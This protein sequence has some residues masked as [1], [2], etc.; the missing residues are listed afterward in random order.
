M[1]D[2]KEGHRRSECDVGSIE[3]YEVAAGR[4]YRVRY[5][6]PD[7]TQ[8]DK[9]GFRTKRDAQL[10]LASVEI[11]KSRGAY[12]DPSKTRATVS[13][14]MRTWMKARPDM[15][16]TTRTRVDGII[17]NYIDPPLG[18]IPI[19]ELNRLRVQEWTANL[20]GSPASIRKVVNVLSGAL[21]LAVDDGRLP[22]NPAVKL[23]LPKQ[24]RTS[25]LYL[26]HD[27]VAALAGAVSARPS[28]SALGYDTLILTMSYCGLRWGE[29]S[30]L[31]TRDVDLAK[32]RLTVQQTVV[33]DKGY[34]RVEAPK[35][36]EHRSIP[37]PGFLIEP[38][39]RQLAG[40]NDDTPVFYG[41]LTKTWLRNHA[42]RKGWLDPAA[43]EIGVPGLTPHELR[44]T[45][46]SLA[47]S[48]GANVKAVQRILGHASAAITL[49]VY[50]DLFDDDLDTVA[51]ALDN[52]AMQ[53]D[54]GKMW[55]E[56]QN[57]V[58]EA[59]K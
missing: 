57:R 48:A 9:R 55:A 36:Y 25:K 59:R 12:V 37:I 1:S 31:R 53:S 47:I 49:D 18:Q 26:T 23:N 19:G 14:W 41:K 2:K 40:R 44:H 21:Q 3:S 51:I 7:R 52:A 42:F 38:L 35:D 16:A 11:D 34:Q 6:K 8:T 5:R 15:R 22:A 20:P 54:V 24:T 32:R 28:G 10:F 56:S 17:R 33:T 45:A 46:A 39:R 43:I 27:Q 58:P 30:G 50:S 29:L 4:R 13:E